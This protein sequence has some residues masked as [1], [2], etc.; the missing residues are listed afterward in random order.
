MQLLVYAKNSKQE[1]ENVHIFCITSYNKI[2]K[3][4]KENKE[5][6]RQNKILEHIY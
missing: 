3:G 6:K 4:L 5:E 2:V 1:E